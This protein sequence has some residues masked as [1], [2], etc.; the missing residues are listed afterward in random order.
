MVASQHLLHAVSFG[1]FPPWGR[2]LALRYA[3]PC[4]ACSQTTLWCSGR[5]HRDILSIAA[6][7]L[8]ADQP[9]CPCRSTCQPHVYPLELES[10]HLAKS[11]AHPLRPAGGLPDKIGQHPDVLLMKV[12]ESLAHCAE[13]RVICLLGVDGGLL[14]VQ[15]R[16]R[17]NLA[18]VSRR[19]PCLERVHFPPICTKH[20]A[21]ESAGNAPRAG[22]KSSQGRV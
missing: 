17:V 10:S 22:Q 20:G 14:R 16:R 12:T 5:I 15:D 8:T 18:P 7:P 9:R 11:A 13:L 6:S 19:P 3:S 21:K 1:G 2:S 4:Y